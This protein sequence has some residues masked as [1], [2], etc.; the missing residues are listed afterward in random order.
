MARVVL[1]LEP[2]EGPHTKL[3]PRNFSGGVL[4]KLK[5]L[6]KQIDPEPKVLNIANTRWAGV[7]WT[8][9]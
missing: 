9:S 7:P 6:V 5:Q 2:H 1:H 3:F 8:V 4:Q